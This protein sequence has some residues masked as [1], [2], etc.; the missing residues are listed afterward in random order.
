[1]KRLFTA[2][3]LLIAPPLGAQETAP[4]PP[5]AWPHEA[6]IPKPKP[7]SV[8]LAGT[9][10]DDPT[11]YFLANGPSAGALS[12]DG[13]RLAYISRVT[14]QPQVWVV[15]A[16]GGSPRQL[17]F[18]LGVDGM[19]W[20]PDGQ[21][22]MYVADKGGDERY[23]FY[24]VSADGTRER[25]LVPPSAAFTM[26]GDYTAD[27]RGL[28]YATTARDGK[29]FDLHVA[30]LDGSGSRPVR[31]GRMGYYPSQVQPNGTLAIVSES[32]GETGQDVYLVDLATGSE[33]TLFKPRQASA[34][35]SFAWTPD[36]RGFY[37]V[38][39][40]DRDFQALAHH[41]LASGRTRI[42]EAPAHDVRSVAVSPD[43]RFLLWTTD[44]G[45]VHRLHA[46]DLRD[47]RDL[48]APPLPAG[49]LSAEFA[50]GAPVAHIEVSGPR[51]P[52]EL[53]VWDLASGRSRRVVEPNAA[54]LDLAAMVE[55]RLVTFPARD[56]VR[57]S[58]LLY[59][60]RDVAGRAP[61]YLQLHG[62]PSAHAGAYWQPSTQYLLAQGVAVLDFNYRGSTGAGKKHSHLNDLR[63]RGKEIDDVV[64]AVR[65]IGR[66]PGLDGARVA[67]G[68]GSYGGYLTNALMG[69]HPDLFAAGVSQV[70][71][72]DWVANLER[73]SPQL[74]ASDRLE[75]GDVRDPADRKFLQSLSPMN[76]VAKIR[77]PFLVQVGAN[78]PRN[79]PQEQ[80]A[81]VTAI[82]DAG[83]QVIYRRYP[84]EGHGIVNLPN[85]LDWNRTKAAFLVEHLRP[86]RTAAR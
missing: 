25:V 6:D 61:V 44:E 5:P 48:P 77:R 18:G 75:Y 12:P 65:W 21:G 35:R 47:G 56:G 62:G 43:G 9:A 68:G 7:V 52:G 27:G 64:D 42:V 32:R 66:Q 24:W 72:A 63:E 73:A 58:G 39:D 53:W 22:L 20:T 23:G 19:S 29:S 57:L 17:T 86:R 74:Q 13:E 11:R 30:A 28:V 55:P 4:P 81:F 33:R 8:P 46:R 10:T 59:E 69:R 76:W 82:R 84:D 79:G 26:P 85:I 15:D 54:G 3:A 40:Q 45:G 2:C 78:D 16:A 37:M 1:M 51:T 31:Q 49:L 83:G 38:T 34:Y 80:D 67:V 14:G 36:G 41:D 60:P 50:R 71:V 70:G